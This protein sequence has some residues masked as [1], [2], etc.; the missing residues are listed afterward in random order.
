MNRVNLEALSK[1]WVG[2]HAN[3]DGEWFGRVRYTTNCLGIKIVFFESKKY[4][5]SH[6]SSFIHLMFT[7]NHTLE[8][9]DTRLYDDDR[10]TSKVARTLVNALLNKRHF[11]FEGI[12]WLDL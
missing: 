5:D 2:S 10:E 8:F 4:L 9:V 7:N 3:E 11:D 6:W 12:D 1:K